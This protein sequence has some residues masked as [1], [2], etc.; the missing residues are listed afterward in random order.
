[1]TVQLS[2]AVRNALLDQVEIAIGTSAKLM[3]YTSTP[4]ANC[5]AAT[6]GTLLVEFDLLSDWAA[7]ASA[8]SKAFSSTP[9]SATAVGGGTAGYYRVYASDG[10]TCHMQG[11][12]TATGGGGDATIDN[13]LI[14]L[15]QSVVISGWTVTAPGA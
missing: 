4:P 9:I 7:A 14:V 11:T 8:G 6:S 15:G 3:L 10:A 12:V 1:M 13:A 2:T 5:A